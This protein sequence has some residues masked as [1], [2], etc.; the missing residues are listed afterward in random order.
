MIAADNTANLFSTELSS[1]LLV[2]GG[3]QA[4][5]KA[6]W[7]PLVQ[8]GQRILNRLFSVGAAI[9]TSLAIGYT[10]NPANNGTLVLTG[11]SVVSLAHGL[12]HVFTQFIYQET[13]YSLLQGLQAA[14]RI[15]GQLA[16]PLPVVPLEQAS[17]PAPLAGAAVQTSTISPA[18]PAGPVSS[19]P[20]SSSAA[21][22]AAGAPSET[23]TP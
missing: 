16:A 17:L 22:P 9:C 4:L 7:F 3:M 12:F 19:A 20:P 23:K 10:W 11:I 2:V 6:K 13:G 18:P 21:L 5:K 1:T 15:T 8:E 14:Q